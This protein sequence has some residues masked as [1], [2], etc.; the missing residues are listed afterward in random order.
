MGKPQL[1]CISIGKLLP[2]NELVVAGDGVNSRFLTAEAVRNDKSI[3]R[4]SAYG[5]ICLRIRATKIERQARA[6][7][8]SI[9]EDNCPL[10]QES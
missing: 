3:Q 7:A 4:K 8:S 10:A 5:R 9:A 1:N 6:E 2:S